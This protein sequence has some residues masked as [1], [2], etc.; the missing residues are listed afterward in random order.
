MK[1]ASIWN[2]KGGQ[3][4]SMVSI[5]LAAAA[6]EIGLKP[7]VIDRDEQGTSML[8]HQAGN[9]PFEVLPD[10]P[11]ASPDVD[12]VLIDHMANDRDMPR[13]VLLVMPVMPKRS[14][15]AAYVEA[16]KYAEKTDKRIITIVT[17]GDMR[18]IQE[19]NVVLALKQRGAFEVRASGVF[20]RAD[21]EYR[22]IFDPSMNTAYAIKDRRHE[23][24]AILSAVLQNQQSEE[25]NHAT[26]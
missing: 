15:Y 16:L 17:N 19:R 10:Y 13:P 3:G 24:S 8:Y 18:R 2:P 7:I 20:S 26:T 21:N 5:N 23:F 9:L 22:T 1:I 12:L 11:K 6:V 14:Q 25:R 4:K